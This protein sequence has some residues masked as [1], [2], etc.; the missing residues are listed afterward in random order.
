MIYT[1]SLS[2]AQAN[3][4][5]APPRPALAIRVAE[6]GTHVLAIVRRPEEK[7]EPR[8]AEGDDAA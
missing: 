2:A 4:W 8:M 5:L 1:G 3:S 7:K 6:R